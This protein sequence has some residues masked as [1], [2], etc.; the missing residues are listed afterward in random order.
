MAPVPSA[1]AGPSPLLDGIPSPRRPPP[2]LA[3]R[4]CH[5]PLAVAAVVVLATLLAFSLLGP[6]FTGQDYGE[7][8]A[9]ESQPPSL[10]HPMGTDGLGRDLLALV[11]R[12]V[13]RSVV[14][15]LLVATI[16]TLVGVAV[17][18]AAGYFRGWVDEM[19]ARSIDLFLVV[20]E[21]AVLLVLSNRAR[22]QRDNWLLVA[23]TISV[24]TWPVIARVTRAAFLSLRRTGYVEAA[25]AAGAS[26]RRIIVRHVVPNAAGPIV[27]AAT[28]AVSWAILTEATL[29]FLGFGPTRPDTSLGTLVEAGTRSLGTRPW[30]FYFPGATLLVIC[31]CVNF[32]GD[33]LRDAL[34]SRLER[35][36]RRRPGSRRAR[37]PGRRRRHSSQEA[38]SRST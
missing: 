23:L 27:V 34:D 12:G 4:F 14:V 1:G 5:Q 38:G 7:L 2:S 11:G 19:I 10:S 3:R 9:D 29:A 30:L 26:D 25:R 13:Q 16:S 28:L 15:G 17:G 32:V 18:A 35:R 36:D 22:S 24:V 21:L 8:S 37:D 31:L 6:T 20:P 33:G